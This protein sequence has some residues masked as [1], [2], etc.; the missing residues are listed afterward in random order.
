MNGATNPWIRAAAADVA[1]H[2]LVNVFIT[3]LWLLAQQNRGAHQLARL[4]VAALRNIFFYPGA[5]QRMA[6]VSRQSFD[7]G[8][9][10]TLH[11]RQRRYAG[12]SR[13]AINVHG[14]SAA[15]RHAAAVLGAG[16]PE[17]VAQNPEERSGRLGI[18]FHRLAIHGEADHE[19]LLRQLREFLRRIAR[20]AEKRRQPVYTLPEI[21]SCAWLRA[22]SLPGAAS[23][24]MCHWLQ[25][26]IQRAAVSM[27]FAAIALQ[28]CWRLP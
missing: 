3:G 12:T 6:Q 22:T 25:P 18:Y 19:S 8:Y 9:L 13:F 5:L 23:H 26:R 4:A 17:V 16:Q 7:G 24:P 14:A 27:P 28:Y 11:A 10:L 2:G 20:R 1:G 21:E 15:E